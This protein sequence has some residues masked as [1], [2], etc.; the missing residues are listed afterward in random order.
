MLMD[1]HEVILAQSAKGLAEA[2]L[3]KVKVSCGILMW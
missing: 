1:S 2:T 3:V